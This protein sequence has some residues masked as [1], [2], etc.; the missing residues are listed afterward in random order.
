ML[1][2]YEAVVQADIIKDKIEV[3]R[4]EGTLPNDVWQDGTYSY[5]FSRLTNEYIHKEECEQFMEKASAENLRTVVIDGG[6]DTGD[7]FRILCPGAGKYV[8][9]SC[10][11]IPMDCENGSRVVIITMRIIRSL[12][13]RTLERRTQRLLTQVDKD[14]LTGLLNKSA[15][16]TSIENFLAGEGASGHHALLLCDIDNFKQMNDS[17]GHPFGDALLTDISDK[18]IASCRAGD[19][20]CR[21]GGDEFILFIK[22]IRGVKSISRLAAEIC[23]AVR[24]SFRYSDQETM[25]SASIGI[26]LYPDNGEDFNTLYQNADRAMYNVKQS[27]KNKFCFFDEALS[28]CRIFAPRVS[29]A[30]PERSLSGI[31]EHITD[32]IFKTLYNSEDVIKTIPIVLQLLGS[33]YDISRV[34]FME[35]RERGRAT[36][37]CQWTADGIPKMKE[38]AAVSDALREY[39]DSS[40]EDEK[41]MLYCHDTE[42]LPAA[43]A[44]FFRELG[45][46]DVRSLM[47]CTLLD[48]GKPC[49]IIGFQECRHAR[50]MWTAEESQALSYV[51]MLIS[52]FLLKQ[53]AHNKALRMLRMSDEIINGTPS[54]MYVVDPKTHKILYINS[55]IKEHVPGCEVGS[56]CY[57]KFMGFDAPCDF[58]PMQGWINQG[59]QGIYSCVCRSD[60]LDDWTE[61]TATGIRWFDDSEVCLCSCM[62][63]RKYK[64]REQELERRV[65][66][67]ESALD[68]GKK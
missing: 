54:M 38:E 68:G 11:F 46:K 61:S 17:F 27:G 5:A 13:L 37:T 63:V 4:A 15:A 20:I 7:E 36:M 64:K 66:E 31:H 21:I 12:R 33:H 51:S 1:E 67:L 62:S 22:D 34:Y 45:A 8:W 25:L 2:R 58:C 59:R 60:L 42:K 41:L 9:C 29:D 53:R 24:Q 56:T 43:A 30:V 65:S 44:E 48:N 28:E 26:A 3:I 32:Y 6:K 18:L 23:S 19:Y 35:C 10:G 49:G 16:R 57:E 50:R 14:P 47:Q 55:K 52:T 39:F 40:L